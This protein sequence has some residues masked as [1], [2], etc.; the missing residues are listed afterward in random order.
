MP[1][2]KRELLLQDHLMMQPRPTLEGWLSA[3]TKK[4]NSFAFKYPD[5]AK[6]WDYERN[7]N[8]TPDMVSAGSSKKFWRI[9]PECTTSY[10]IAP[11]TWSTTCRCKECGKIK[12]KEQI[13]ER[14]KAIYVF[15]SDG[16]IAYEFQSCIE[17]SDFLKISKPTLYKY[18]SS[19]L[20]LNKGLYR[21]CVLWYASQWNALN[22]EA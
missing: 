16:N 5:K 2:L 10:K 20:P 22:V 6:E 9:C 13:V 19:H 8:I 17:A 18:A 14:C 7:G 1:P 3:I 15:N 4:E 21:G 12:S 11:S